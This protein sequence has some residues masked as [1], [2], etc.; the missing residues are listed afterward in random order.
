MG[1]IRYK[2]GSTRAS[3]DGEPEELHMDEMPKPGA[4]QFKV[5]ALIDKSSDAED[6]TDAES[7]DVEAS[8]TGLPTIQ[9]GPVR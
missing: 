9:S 6:S 1:P 2:S 8:M 5:C 4:R 3:S 7:P